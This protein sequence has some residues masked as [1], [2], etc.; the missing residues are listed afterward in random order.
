MGLALCSVTVTAYYR[1]DLIPS[2]WVEILR[3]KSMLAPFPLNVCSP[4]LLAPSLLSHRGEVLAQE[5][6]VWVLGLGQGT[7]YGCPAGVQYPEGVWWTAYL[8]VSGGSL[9]GGCFRSELSVS[10]SWAQALVWRHHEA[11]WSKWEWSIFLAQSGLEWFMGNWA[12]IGAVANPP[13]LPTLWASKHV[14]WRRQ[15][16]PTPVLLPGK[17]HVRRSLV[18]CS[19]WGC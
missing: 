12:A 13:L 4:T 2:C 9:L 1:W 18:G 11:S 5:E 19:P 7:G 16:H 6:L 14:L 17:S 10:H 3:V 8:C 15:W